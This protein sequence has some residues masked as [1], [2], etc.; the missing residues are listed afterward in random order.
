MKNETMWDLFCEWEAWE[1]NKEKYAFAE[2]SFDIDDFVRLVKETMLII[3]EYRAWFLDF[4]NHIVKIKE[5]TGEFISL[6]RSITLYG[7]SMG[8]DKS[9]NHI[10]TIS[11]AIAKS[12]AEEASVV[13]LGHKDKLFDEKGIIRIYADECGFCCPE[14]EDPNLEYWMKTFLYDTNTGDISGL[15]ELAKRSLG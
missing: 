5:N 1:G 14:R 4:D 13:Q 6:I 11:Q 9:E 10:F 12:L 3:Q 7:V 8:I 15:L 2:E